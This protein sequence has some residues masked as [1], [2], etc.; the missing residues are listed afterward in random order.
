MCTNLL[1]AWD[2]NADDLA[3]RVS[4]VV[5]A[6]S[7]LE[8]LAAVKRARGWKNL[9][10][11][12]ALADAFTRDYDGCPRWRGASSSVIGLATGQMKSG[13]PCSAFLEDSRRR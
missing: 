11:A 3:Q 5:V 2:G 7:R 6:R 10:L 8:R 4:L 12:S 13:P 1:D 9:R